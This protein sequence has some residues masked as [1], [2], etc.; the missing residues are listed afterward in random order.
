MLGI[1]VDG[2]AKQCQL[3]ERNA[4]HHGKGQAIPAQL[5]ELL[6]DHGPQAPGLNSIMSAL[7]RQSYRGP[8][9]SGG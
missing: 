3:Q 4:D 2:K 7:P 1:T 9:A 6:A 8:T 5:D